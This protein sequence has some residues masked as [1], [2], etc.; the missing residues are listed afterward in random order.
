VESLLAGAALIA[1]G[2]ALVGLLSGVA[3]VTAMA[4][5]HRRR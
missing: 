5:S 2:G 4:A 1:V 3:V